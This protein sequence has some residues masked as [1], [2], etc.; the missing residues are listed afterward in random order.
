MS[1]WT[2]DTSQWPI[3]I[4]SVEG[5]LSDRQIDDYL[6]EATALMDRPEPYIAI[7][8]ASRI[9]SVSAYMRARITE[10]QRQHRAI[11][12]ERCVGVV[13]VL[14]SPLLRFVTMTILLVT[15]LG[16]PYVVCATRD[17]AL[18]WARGRASEAMPTSGV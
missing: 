17:E 3:V 8:D 2:I 12:N 16:V 9:G 6:R 10:W 13:Y 11:V 14:S 5:S 15:G 4:H 18:A 7:M 1:T